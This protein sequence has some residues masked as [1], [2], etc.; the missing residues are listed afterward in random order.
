MTLLAPCFPYLSRRPNRATS[1]LQSL[2]DIQPELLGTMASGTKFSPFLTFRRSTRL[3]NAA[4]EA[5]LVSLATPLCRL[6]S[7][8]SS[9]LTQIIM[10][11]LLCVTVAFRGA[12]SCSVK[13]WKSRG[14]AEVWDLLLHAKRSCSELQVFPIL[15]CD[16]FHSIESKHH[17]YCAASS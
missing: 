11:S 7:S 1:Y 3:E 10:L 16:N 15:N 17:K 4:N 8:P 5:N 12:A 2:Y 13:V 9:L 14:C 6:I